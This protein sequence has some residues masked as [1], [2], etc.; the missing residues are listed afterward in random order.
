MFEGIEFTKIEAQKALG[1]E[2]SVANGDERIFDQDAQNIIEGLKDYVENPDGPLHFSLGMKTI[3]D[4][5]RDINSQIALKGKPEKDLRRAEV[6]YKYYQPRR[7]VHYTQVSGH[8][9]EV[10]VQVRRNKRQ[11]RI[12]S[13][14]PEYREEY[15]SD[16]D[17]PRPSTSVHTRHRGHAILHSSD[18]DS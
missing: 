2:L 16:S 10:E 6:S 15:D 18:L 14:S 17:Q 11:Q 1:V 13:G 5:K 9:L 4:H 7:K 3:A 8:G 12:I